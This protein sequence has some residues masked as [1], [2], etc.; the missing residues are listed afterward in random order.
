MNLYSIQRIAKNGMHLEK[1]NTIKY[2][3]DSPRKV[4][5]TYEI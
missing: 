2:A 3:R 5:G 1:Q 4:C